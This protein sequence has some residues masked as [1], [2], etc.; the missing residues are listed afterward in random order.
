MVSYA[1][2]QIST[3]RARP[4]S[5]TVLGVIGIL[6]AAM[7]LLA[8]FSLL[9][10]WASLHKQ[11]TG[12]GPTTNPAAAIQ[13][14][15]FSGPLFAWS[16]ASTA[17]RFALGGVLLWASIQSLRLRGAGRRG[18]VGYAIVAIVWAAIGTLVAS[19]YVVPRTM[20]LLASIGGSGMPPFVRTFAL[21]SAIVGG[22]IGMIY[23]ACVLVFFRRRGV[24][25]AFDA[26]DAARA[27]N[28]AIPGR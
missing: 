13:A 5:V 9:L 18:M 15:L 22:L 11:A 21:V 25:A 8:P 23:P 2:P 24:V 7:T 3:A 1:T 20:D 6:L 17:V 19:L 27:E 12:A 26:A 28:V 16:L 4:T 10:Q 14:Q